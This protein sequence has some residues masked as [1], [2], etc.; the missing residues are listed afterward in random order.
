MS[1]ESTASTLTLPSDRE[2]E[3]SRVFNA[4]RDLV[5]AAYTDPRHV[6]NWW[7]TGNPATTI[8]DEMDVRPGGRWRWVVRED[9]VEYGFRGEYVEVVPP[10]KL[11]YT[12]EF[13][14]PSGQ[15]IYTLT[16]EEL[17]GKTKLTART[18]FASKEVRD[19]TLGYGM[20]S[21]ANMAWDQLEA[22]LATLE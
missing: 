3:M 6:P 10:E 19:A 14:P 2:I 21:G 8:V 18:L 9:G 17:D 5:W 1:N 12:F 11:V 15:M 13:E 20:E 16:F 22:L 4:P 7:G